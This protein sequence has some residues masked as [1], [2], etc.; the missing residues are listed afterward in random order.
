MSE[1]KQ[2]TARA[3]SIFVFVLEFF[4][5]Y[6]NIQGRSRDVTSSSVFNF[7]FFA[8]RALFYVR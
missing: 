8:G 5:K 3:R 2:K 6:L 4:K 7:D 1:V